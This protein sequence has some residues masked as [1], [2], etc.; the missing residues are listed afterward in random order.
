M[1]T[2][3]TPRLTLVAARALQA[4]LRTE[5]GPVRWWLLLI[6][7]GSLAPGA[8]GDLITYEGWGALAQPQALRP[9]VDKT[10]AYND[11]AAIRLGDRESLADPIVEEA[12]RLLTGPWPPQG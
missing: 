10:E 3:S 8:G 5:I 4:M 6:V 7:N 2:P 1:N 9:L 11:R 12:Q